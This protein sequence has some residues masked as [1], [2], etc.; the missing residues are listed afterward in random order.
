MNVVIIYHHIAL[1][2]LKYLNP[3][4]STEYFK[5]ESRRQDIARVISN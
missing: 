5:Y 2:V 3:S 1:R 4:L